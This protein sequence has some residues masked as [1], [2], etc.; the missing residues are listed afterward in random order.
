MRYLYGLIFGMIATVASSCSGGPGKESV[1]PDYPRIYPDYVNVTI[2]VNI[3]PLN[4][5]LGGTCRRI[6]VR[7]EGKTGSIRINSGNKVRIPIRKW[8]KLLEANE[9]D[10]VYISTK[11]LIGNNWVR[12][13]RFGIFVS[14]DRIDPYLSY[15]LI[16][17]GY[18]VWNRLTIRE[19]NLKNYSERILADNNLTGD[20]CI[21]CHTYAGQD[22]GISF[23]HIR[24]SRG[25][26]IIQRN[27]IIRKINTRTDSTV[28]AG[29]Y[30]SWHPGGRFIA[31]STNVIIPGF[32]TRGDRRLEVYDTISDVVILDTEKDQV[33]SSPRTSLRNSFET[34]PAFSA[35]G[36]RLYFCSAAAA[37]MP[38]NYKSV[39]YSLCGVDFDAATGKTGQAVDTI[40]S[41][42]GTGKS[43]SEPKCSPDGRY[44]L[45][46]SF[47]YGNFPVWHEEADLHLLDL[48]T[49]TIDTL[50][51]VNSRRSDSYH[52]WSSGS[53]WFVFAS[54]RDD[55]MYG[56]PYFAHTDSSGKASKPFLMP[57]RDPSFYDMF[58]KSYNIP[59]FSKGPASFDSRDIRRAF[60]KLEAE[61]VTFVTR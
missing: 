33:I 26:T 21:N 32:H 41:A 20:G 54:K 7:I 8:K 43:V 1:S 45:F 55:G 18:E 13:R 15:R 35:D 56:K 25:G 30:G 51:D 57:Q 53:R 29:V 59:E 61:K 36:T 3:A 48:R 24:H 52:S 27:G 46:T 40:I 9:G 44:L 50:A 14:T 12:Y 39:R 10:S 47:D 19:R 22:P 16:E 42:Y 28:S 11:A 34:F 60:G 38:E 17:P 37:R 58:L 2:P 4:F 31:F 6:I 23:L 49:M 5:M